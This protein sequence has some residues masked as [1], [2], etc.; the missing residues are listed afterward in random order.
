MSRDAVAVIGAGPAGLAAAHRLV[1]AGR[2]VEVFEASPFVGGIARSVTRW[3]TSVDLGPHTFAGGDE[4]A[5][6]LWRGAVGEDAEVLPLRRATLTPHGLVAYPP[7][8]RDLLRTLPP[9][10]LLAMGTGY[11]RARA[12][13]QVSDASSAE[14]W[15]VQRYGRGVYDALLRNYLEKLWGSSG[16]ELDRAF[17]QS[18]LGTGTAHAGRGSARPVAAPG[19][20]FLYPRTGGS[21]RVWETLAAG[22][23]QSGTIHHGASVEGICTR[24]GRVRALVIDGEER[25]FTCVIS[26]LPVARLVSLLPQPP[27]DVLAAAGALR[28]RHVVIAHLLLHGAASVPYLWLFVEDLRL[29]VGRVSDHRSYHPSLPPDAAAVVT[30]EYWCGEGDEIWSRPDDVI[31]STARSELAA[32]GLYQRVDV[33]DTSVTRLAHALPVPTLGYAGPLEVLRGVVGSIR[34]LQSIGRHGSFTAGSMA[35]V[36]GEGLAAAERVLRDTAL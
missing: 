22:I 32:L 31:A 13:P 11:L 24:G 7:R 8:P 18:L 23:R 19:P 2:N 21:S 12:R 27:V 33:R 15:V 34:G 29:R 25:E 16:Q 35:D 9:S 28:T 14:A 10:R 5:L 17:A 26:T 20:T 30:M 36:M 1:Q 4:E 6:Q 3:G